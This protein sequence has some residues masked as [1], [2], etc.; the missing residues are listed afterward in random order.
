MLTMEMINLE[1][2]PTKTKVNDCSLNILNGYAD[3]ELYLMGVDPGVNFG[4]T[5]IQD[6]AVRVLWGHLPG[7]KKLRGE[8]GYQM[9]NLMKEICS[10][11]DNVS[12]CIVEGA[13][14]N[15]KFGQVGL[16]EVREG[17]YLAARCAGLST[18]ISP[19]A[20]IKAKVLGHGRAQAGDWF[21]T[22]NH[23]ACDSISVALYGQYL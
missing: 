4:I 7:T 16:E 13:A 9:Y 23:N 3:T 12:V 19:P 17:A 14:F 10:D 20:T 2:K 22:L 6:G 1:Q 11:V 15:A 21:P 5:V 8:R 18:F